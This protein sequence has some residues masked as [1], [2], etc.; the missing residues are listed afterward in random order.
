MKNSSDI[1]RLYRD[2]AYYVKKLNQLNQ[3][4]GYWVDYGEPA[5]ENWLLTLLER[6]VGAFVDAILARLDKYRKH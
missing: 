2:R 3:Q 1:K 4:L 5:P 6:A